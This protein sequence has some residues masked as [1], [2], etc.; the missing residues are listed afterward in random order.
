MFP[1][2]LCET[3]H[4]C[5]VLWE[6]PESVIV[7]SDP[8]CGVFALVLCFVHKVANCLQQVELF[9]VAYSF[10]C[11]SERGISHEDQFHVRFLRLGS[12]NERPDVFKTIDDILKEPS[13]DPKQLVCKLGV[14]NL[15]VAVMWEMLGFDTDL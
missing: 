5:V 15:F 11:W 12:M 14:F 8:N 6:R 13:F 7:M 4:V 10:V 1:L 9:V 2:L 3:E